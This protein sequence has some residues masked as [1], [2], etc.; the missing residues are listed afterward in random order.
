LSTLAAG[1]G[2]RRRD[3]SYFSVGEPAEFGA[4]QAEATVVDA[5]SAQALREAPRVRRAW[6]GDRAR[7]EL[8]QGFDSRA[9]SGPANSPA[10][11]QRM[12]LDV[13][14]ERGRWGELDN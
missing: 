2:W 13:S 8:R 9:F 4:A 7:V 1:D 5:L 11:G 14:L 6:R 12:I 3:R 10:R